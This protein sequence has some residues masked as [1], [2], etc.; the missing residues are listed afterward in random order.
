MKQLVFLFVI[1]MGVMPITSITPEV[2]DC[3]DAYIELFDGS[4]QT[5]KK[6]GLDPF[7][8]TIEDGTQRFI[9][10]VVCLDEEIIL[11][12]YSHKSGNDTYYDGF[13]TVLDLD[14]NI[15][16]EEMIE[17]GMLE[18][19][20][21]MFIVDQMYVFFVR[22]L[23]ENEQWDFNRDLF[24]AYDVNYELYGDV[25]VDQEVKN[26]G[27]HNDLIL[28]D[29]NY[30]TEYEYGITGSLELI[31]ENQ[32]FDLQSSYTGEVD[33]KFIN[34]ATLNGDIVSNGITVDYPG[35]YEFVY[36]D[37]I[38]YFM[39]APSIEG[40]VDMGIYTDPVEITYSS[41]KGML[42]GELFAS[43]ETVSEPGNYVLSVSGVGGYSKEYSFVIVPE[44]DG[45]IDGQM[46]HDVFTITFEGDGYLNNN[47]VTS[48]VV[49]TQEGDYI[50]QVKGVNGYQDSYQFGLYY[51]D[52]G[53]GF[54]DVIKNIDI[55]IMVFVAIV[56]IVIL[57]KK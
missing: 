5:I 51:S 35:N 44:V 11:Y 43:G 20:H 34:D 31:D 54:D 3:K 36:N 38:Y 53:I 1:M 33:L 28:L 32:I 40:I 7:N 21:D 8:I 48:P 12:G 57:K 15:I 46:Y 25:S 29:F 50:L 14:G 18:E 26:I 55:F 30:D 6:I 24:V 19:V 49:I 2:Y 41:G 42:N 9:N 45:V 56:G 47:L 16:H 10:D 27:F 17:Y 52:D 22:Q 13:F 39:I 37:Q 23:V 4:T